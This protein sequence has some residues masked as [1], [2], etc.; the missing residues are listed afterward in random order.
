MR[1]GRCVRCLCVKK[2]VPCI[3]YW[4]S[5]INPSRCEN[6]PSRH[7]LPAVVP[8]DD[9]MNVDLPQRATANQPCHNDLHTPINTDTSF[10]NDCAIETESLSRFLSQPIKILKRIPRL[11]RVTASRKLASVVEQVVARN[12]IPS[13]TRLLSFSKKCL[14]TPRR[15]GKRW[16]LATLVNKQVSEESP[17]IELHAQGV[18]ANPSGRRPA[19]STNN[20]VDH[21]H[22]ATRISMKLE[23]GDYRGAVRL[24]CSEDVFAEYNSHTLDVLRAKHLPAPPDSSMD[25]PTCDVPLSISVETEAI[26]RAIA[27][28]P[29]GSGA[30]MDGLRP[31]HLKDL[32]GPSAGDGGWLFCLP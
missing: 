17:N 30:G 26:V 31:Q 1:N 25:A 9:P 8:P 6:F 14:C 11:S 7:T 24:A 20:N 22:Q 12:D 18:T 10:S 29:C 23:E 4:P 16:S 3:D 21:M 2:G 27:S 5:V 32:T 13:W 19:F 15:G 28:F